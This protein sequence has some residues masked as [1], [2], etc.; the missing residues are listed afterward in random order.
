MRGE[1]I[2][3]LDGWRGLA[4]L[5]VMVCHMGNQTGFPNNGAH[6]VELFF[7][8]S[9]MLITQNL[10]REL[11]QT[12]TISLPNFYKRRFQRL[13][14][15]SWVYMLVAGSIFATSPLAPTAYEWISA[16]FCFRN[17]IHAPSIVLGHFWSLSVEEQFYFFWPALLLLFRRK[18]AYVALTLALVCS[19][20]RTIDSPIAPSYTQYCADALLVG[21]LISLVP[22]AMKGMKTLELWIALLSFA[23]IVCAYSVAP[24]YEPFVIAIL[25]KGSVSTEWKFRVLLEWKPL[26]FLGRI[27]Y[28]VYLWQNVLLNTPFHSTAS[29]FIKPALTVAVGYASWR[30]L[31]TPFRVRYRTSCAGRFQWS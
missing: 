11:D 18:S 21:C 17:Y 5:G 8:L 19:L 27:S 2:A 23:G 25:L 6:G 29:L 3:S 10:L 9:G 4:I 22:D 7:V 30:L 1:R 28:S 20:W 24:L 13:M 12:G 14:P 26:V 16:V 31:E 15:A